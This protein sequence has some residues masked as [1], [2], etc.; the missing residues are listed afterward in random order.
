MAT[1]VAVHHRLAQAGLRVPRVLA[2]CPD[3]DELG[4]AWFIMEFLEGEAW[5]SSRKN[6]PSYLCDLTDAAIARQSALVNAIQG[7]R[8]GRW[9]EDHCSSLSWANSF[10]AMVEDVLADARD[11]SVRLPRSETALRDL[12]Q[13]AH[14][15]LDLVK[16]PY[17]VLWDVHDSNVIVKYGTAELAG[18][19]DTDRALWG[20]P[21]M[22]FY[23]RSLANVSTAWQ[24]AYRQVCIE[25]GKAY[26]VDTPGAVQRMVLYDLY[27]ALIIVVEV[28]Y[29]GYGPDQD[30][31]ARSICDQALV[32]CDSSL[33]QASVPGG[34]NPLGG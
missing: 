9:Q 25:S 24:V 11:K 29:R 20:D 31:W 13:A 30:A 5:G 26:P 22:E 2:D 3:G 10:Q 19:L 23:F 7:E 18:F 8:F 4:H 15:I 14:A 27:L 28:A 16:I 1:E 34:A 6:Q 33:S 21:L 17:L 12:F 32:A